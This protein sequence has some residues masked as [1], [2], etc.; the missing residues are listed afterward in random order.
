MRLNDRA[1]DRV[2]LAGIVVGA[3]ARAA[4]VFWLH[5][6]LD[7]LYSDMGLYVR[8]ASEI[9]RGHDLDVYATFQPQG[10]HLLLA[11]PLKLLGSGRSGLWGGAALWWAFSAATPFFAWRLARLL[12]TPAAG[13]VTAI[14]AAI[15]PLHVTLA[16][17]FLSETPSLA[18]LL[19]ALWLGYRAGRQPGRGALWQGVLAG[20]LG[21]VAVAARPQFL[22][23]LTLVAV[24]FLPRRRWSPT[25]VLPFVAAAAALLVAAVAFNTAAAGRLTG[26]SREGGATFF[27]GQCR[28]KT[29]TVHTATVS[30]TIGAP[31]YVQRG[32]AAVDVAG[33]ELWEDGFF[34]RKGLRCIERDGAHYPVHAARMIGDMTATSKPWPQV[35]E[36]TLSGVVD[37]ANKVYG[38]GLLPLIVVV[39]LVRIARRVPTAAGETALLAHLACVIPVAVVFLGDPRFRTPYDVFGLAL[40]AAAITAKPRQ[41]GAFPRGRAPRS[42]GSSEKAGEQAL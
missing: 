41:S 40:A 21:A 6:P 35:N 1:W 26:L 2:A 14:L 27:I 7:Y 39:S 18:F 17:Y 33:H 32:G 23:N 38:Y 16:G 22:L 9:A 12:L 28:V 20:T 29:L 3:A 15:W 42:P 11:L 37:G 8:F 25:A 13:A 5:P 19:A 30:A 36:P 31:P 24:P 10:T 34:Y 4:W